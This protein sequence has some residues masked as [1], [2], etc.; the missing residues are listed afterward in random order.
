MWRTYDKGQ[1]YKDVALE[2][3]LTE[4]VADDDLLC[5]LKV[6]AHND[7][8]CCKEHSRE[9][10]VATLKA[11][12]ELEQYEDPL[13]TDLLWFNEDRYQKYDP[14]G[15]LSSNGHQTNQPMV[16]F[17]TKIVVIYHQILEIQWWIE[18]MSDIMKI[19]RW[20]SA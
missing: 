8:D 17:Q 4:H 16:R 10:Q 15:W 3:L 18:L 7:E 6:E 20:R 2:D 12:T 5:I 14:K 13:L 11:M 19:L 1:L 9:D